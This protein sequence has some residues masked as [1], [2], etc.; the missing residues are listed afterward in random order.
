[1]ERERPPVDPRV[2]RAVAS[3]ARNRKLKAVVER[4]IEKAESRIKAYLLLHGIT[5]AHL[6]RYHVEMNDEGELELTPLSLLD[7]RQPP[8][9]GVGDETRWLSEDE[10]A[11]DEVS[12]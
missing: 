5:S 11:E 12:G 9:P 2:V 1:M 6:G 8:L 10:S 7:G 4:R 3:L